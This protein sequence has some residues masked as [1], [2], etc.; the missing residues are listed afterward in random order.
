M[1]KYQVTRF[2]RIAPKSA[3]RTT[4]WVTALGSMSPL[5]IVA[6]TAVPVRAPAK[7][8][9]AASRMAVR[10]GNTPVLT[11]VATALAASWKPLM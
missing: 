6:A 5:P 10:K 8:K 2:Q 7:F 3:D 9:R 1:P 11:T 4:T